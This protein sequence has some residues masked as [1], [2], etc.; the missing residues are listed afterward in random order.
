MP[1]PTL[2]WWRLQTAFLWCVAFAAVHVYWAVGGNVGL[3]SAAG[4][5]LA[6]R[7]PALFVL[8]GLWGTATLLLLGAGF[9]AGLAEGRPQGRLRRPAAAVGWLLGV[10]LLARGIIL[11]LGLITGAGGIAASVGAAETRWSLVL[12]NPWFALGGVAFLM[13]ARRFGQRYPRARLRPVDDRS[14]AQGV[15]GRCC[16]PGSDAHSHWR[17]MMAAL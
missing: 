12:W 14:A 2:K 6:T 1:G 3:A 9:S 17:R 13:T 8:V 15:P 4:V 16:S 5:D 11:E 7:R 10:T